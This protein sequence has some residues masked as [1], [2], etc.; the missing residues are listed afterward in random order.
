MMNKENTFYVQVKQYLKKHR[1]DALKNP[2]LT[3]KNKV[4]LLFL[5]TA[6]KFVRKMHKMLKGKKLSQA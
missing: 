5:G 6:P 1:R 2:Y 4:Y 3:K